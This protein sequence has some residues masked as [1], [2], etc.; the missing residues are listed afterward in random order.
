[1]GDGFSFTGFAEGGG[2][3]P[4]YES[5]RRIMNAG[6]YPVE[7]QFCSVIYDLHSKIEELCAQ[8]KLVKVLGMGFEYP[9]CSSTPFLGI[10]PW[11][12]THPPAQ[13]LG[14]QGGSDCWAS[15]W[16]FGVRD[17]LFKPLERPTRTP[18]A[19]LRVSA[20]TWKCYAEKTGLTSLVFMIRA[21]GRSAETAQDVASYQRLIAAMKPKLEALFGAT[22]SAPGS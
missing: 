16:C 1:M 18:S 2:F 17:G 4:Q 7:F 13:F 21:F 14:K 12:R 19:T 5:P 3:Q 6:D 10:D 22:A 11:S 20:V 8:A 9:S 15:T